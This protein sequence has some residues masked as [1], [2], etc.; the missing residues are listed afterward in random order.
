MTDKE[1]K[2]SISEIRYARNSLKAKVYRATAMGSLVLGVVT[3]IVAIW[4]YGV[5][6]AEQYIDE[7]FNLARSTTSLLS[8][9][10]DVGEVVDQIRTIYDS[11]SVDEQLKSGTQEYRDHFKKLVNTDDYQRINNIL[12]QM[13]NASDANDLY[14]AMY[15]EDGE[16][17]LYFVDPDENEE[18]RFYAGEWE[19]IEKREADKFLNWDGNGRLYDISRT[20]A[21]GWMCTSGIPLYSAD[22]KLICFVLADL[23]LADL[24][25]GMVN[26]LVHFTL[27]QIVVTV[28]IGYLISRHM[29]KHLVGPINQI[30]RSAQEYI[31]DKKSGNLKKK[32]FPELKID[33]SNEIENLNNVMAQMESGLSAYERNLTRITAENERI[34]T[35]L[36]LATRIQMN[37]LPGTFPAFPDRSE[38]DLYAMMDPAKKV[39]G[40]FYNF[41]LID[42]DHLCLL[43]ADV[44]GKGIPAALFMMASTIIL[45]NLVKQGMSPAEVMRNANETI[46]YGNQEQMFVTVWLGILEISTGKMTAANAGHEYPIIRNGKGDYEVLK[47]KHDF[48]VGGMEDM[49]YSEYELKL[50]K[51]SRLFLYTDGLPEA[52]NKDNAMFGEER[53]LEALNKDKDADPEQQIQNVR[54]AVDD[55]V[56]EVEQFDD[57][58]MLAFEYKGKKKS[59]QKK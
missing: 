2:R 45:F 16:R 21:Y 42:E 55:F 22:G 9:G 29:Q 7:T 10:T 18:T 15:V 37:M 58:T 56:G 11:L 8:K 48:V 40:D 32:H 36:D 19:S 12:L 50:E 52:S 53:I 43:I 41:F 46:C 47:D 44:S 4:L 14:L 1:E 5:S 59:H 49:E 25:N 6:L 57:L 54:K 13:K 38:F 23:L 20:K 26:F 27:A 39:G 24:L 31:E 17:L 51:G 28:L 3:L 33:A 35:E 34:S 30:A